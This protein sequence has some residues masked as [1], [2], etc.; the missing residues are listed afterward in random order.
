[1]AL[2]IRMLF[3]FF[4]HIFRSIMNKIVTYKSLSLLL[5][6]AVLTLF[7]GCKVNKFDK[8]ET[9]AKDLA[10]LKTILAEK[11]YRIAIEVAYPFVSA[12]TTQVSNVLLRNTGNTANRIDLRGDG[13]FIEIKNDTLTGYLPFFG[14]QRLNAGEYGGKDLSIQFEEPL[15]DLKKKID[16]DKGVLELAFTA[17]QKGN[18]NERYDIDVKIYSNKNV[19]VYITPVY[20]TFMRYSGRLEPINDK[21]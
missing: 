7:W 4:G 8:N 20:R 10:V 9:E 13:N 16:S 21:K 1:M 19:S 18:S 2:L 12:A 5:L 15:Q 6:T 17:K 3:I 11:N 14:E